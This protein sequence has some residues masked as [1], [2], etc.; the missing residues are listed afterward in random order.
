MQRIFAA[1]NTL[2]STTMWMSVFLSAIGLPFL[3][4]R[5]EV[6]RY[7]YMYMSSYLHIKRNPQQQPRNACDVFI[8]R[9]VLTG[10]KCFGQ[11]PLLPQSAF[12]TLCQ[13]DRSCGFDYPRQ[14]RSDYN[15][16][17]S[18]SFTFKHWNLSLCGGVNCPYQQQYLDRL[19]ACGGSIAGEHAY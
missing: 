1:F 10:I 9:S 2:S 6:W 3:P 18:R 15:D 8:L 7:G 17:R 16:P 13:A 5:G 11:Y 14:L 4:V 19:K 12:M